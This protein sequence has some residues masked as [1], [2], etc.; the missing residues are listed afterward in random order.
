M[1]IIPA[2]PDETGAP[3]HLHF[4]PL[5]AVDIE[6]YSARMPLMQLKAQKDLLHAMETAAKEAELDRGQWLQQVSGDGELALLPVDVNI[7]TVVG[8]FA[9]ALERALAAM[10]EDVDA[11]RPLRVRL[12]VHYGALIMG[13]DTSFGPAGDAPVVV[14]RLLE[15]RPLRRYLTAHPERN[16][17]LIV[18]AWIF[19][20]VVRSGFCPLPPTH[21]QPVRTTSK[22]AVYHGYVYDPDRESG[23]VKGEVKDLITD[24]GGV[25][26][27]DD[28]GFSEDRGLL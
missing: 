5:L 8:R 1:T 24:D 21:F 10:R 27:L 14:K 13:P 15:A 9:P 4:R 11:V 3:L 17:A 16:V 25:I 28:D 6:G 12:A 18:S 20:E 2:P 23:A 22:G 19:R 7:V 26:R